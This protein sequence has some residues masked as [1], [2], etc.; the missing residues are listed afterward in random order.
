MF[1]L[2]KR[3]KPDPSRLLQALD[4]ENG[5]SEYHKSFMKMQLAILE[6]SKDWEHK[7]EKL[8]PAEFLQML[9]FSRGAMDY[10]AE[11]NFPANDEGG[12]QA[13]GAVRQQ[14]LVAEMFSG[15]YHLNN[16]D[17]QAALL[18]LSLN[19]LTPRTTGHKLAA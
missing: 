5:L 13:L 3:R 14:M 12:L 4:P 2:F 18:K 6:I 1:K 11:H 8:T 15:D 19:D 9:L 10:L 16:I 7:N 17:T